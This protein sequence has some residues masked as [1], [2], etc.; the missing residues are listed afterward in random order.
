MDTLL[1]VCRVH[2]QFNG[3]VSYCGPWTCVCKVRAFLHN[4]VVHRNVGWI[5]ISVSMTRAAL[6]DHW[7]LNSLYN[8]LCWLKSGNHLCCLNYSK[9]GNGRHL[10]GFSLAIK[11]A[12]CQN[13]PLL[14]H[15]I[16]EYRSV[17]HIRLWEPQTRH[18][19]HCS[20]MKTEM[21]I[22]WNQLTFCASEKA[23]QREVR[24]KRKMLTI[25]KHWTVSAHGLSDLMLELIQGCRLLCDTIP[26]RRAMHAKRKLSRWRKKLWIKT[27]SV[28]LFVSSSSS[29]SSLIS[30]PSLHSFLSLDPLENQRWTEWWRCCLLGTTSWCCLGV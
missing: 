25:L 28:H 23:F 29:S 17:W 30:F 16:C 15:L 21:E 2:V 4:V 20:N 14:I 27:P 11:E 3:A 1:L 7:L 18:I 26:R 9:Y 5:Y 6:L 24:G 19:H 13:K 12:W 8:S 22:G 10:S